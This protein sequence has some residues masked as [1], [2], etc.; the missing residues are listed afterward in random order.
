MPFRLLGSGTVVVNRPLTSGA[1]VSRWKTGTPSTLHTR[2]NSA[3]VRRVT[4]GVCLDLSG[5][6]TAWAGG[7][8][9]GWATSGGVR[10]VLLGG[11]WKIMLL[12]TQSISGLCW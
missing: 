6:G 5:T 9:A 10:T 4:L 11:F 1:T 12:F 7:S 2:V 3:G 8:G